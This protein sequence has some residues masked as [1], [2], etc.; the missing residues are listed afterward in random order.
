M[1]PE[2]IVSKFRAILIEAVEKQS[3]IFIGEIES[4]IDV[5]FQVC[6]I[7]YSDT[8]YYDLRRFKSLLSAVKVST[9]KAKLKELHQQLIQISDYDTKMYKVIMGCYKKVSSPARKKK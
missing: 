8:D 5:L 6:G 2:E 3:A 4:Q 7:D 1:S 9:I